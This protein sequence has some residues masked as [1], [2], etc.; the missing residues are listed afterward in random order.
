MSV[1]I[2]SFGAMTLSLAT[3]SIMTLCNVTLIETISKDNSINDIING[4]LT[5]VIKTLLI[6]ALLIA[7][8]N[9]ELHICFYVLL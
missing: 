6:T 4:T 8:I 1:I 7:L 2:V 3:L 9:A 5:I